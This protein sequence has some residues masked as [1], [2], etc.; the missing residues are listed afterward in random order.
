MKKILIHLVVPAVQ[1]EFDI[2]LPL[3]LPVSEISALLSKAVQ[4]LSAGQYVPAENSML[5]LQRTNSL[6]SQDCTPVENQLRNGDV[7]FLL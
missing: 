5:C 4:S 3:D 2:F 7:L 6:L 1:M